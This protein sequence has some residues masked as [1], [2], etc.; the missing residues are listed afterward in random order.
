MKSKS[1]EKLKLNL[2]CGSKIMPGYI[3]V[4]MYG[5]PDIVCNLEETP[6][7][8]EDNS[9]DEII[10]HHSLEHMGQLSDVY[11]AIIQEVYRICCHKAQVMISVPHP[12]HD[13]FITDPTHV[14]MITPNG[15]GMFS[16]RLNQ[17]WVDIGAAN[18][19]LGLYL[20]VDFEVVHT[21]M[22]LDN[23]WMQ[24]LNSG[25][26]S[27]EEVN[28]AVKSQWNVVKEIKMTV[29]VIKSKTE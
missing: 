14:R 6:W 9:V 4:D 21:K 11:L 12:R 25:E 1:N 26:V 29:D 8:W 19:P 10:F 15:L 18:T 17:H 13:H 23:A 24:R 22:V 28:Q 16:K 7:P 2:G 27:N 20:D 5:E 3:N